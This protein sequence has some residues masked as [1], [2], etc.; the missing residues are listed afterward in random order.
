MHHSS[1]MLAST[2]QAT[3]VLRIYLESLIN[4][5]GYSVE[6]WSLVYLIFGSQNSGKKTLKPHQS[7]AVVCVYCNE[8]NISLRVSCV[9][10]PWLQ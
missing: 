7:G 5:L 8:L 4:Y 3:T 10:Y 6:V 1:Y 9:K 2:R